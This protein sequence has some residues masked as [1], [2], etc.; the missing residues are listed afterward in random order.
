MPPFSG[1]PA[2]KCSGARQKCVIFFNKNMETTLE[3][4]KW[5]DVV[6][7][8]WLVMGL[9]GI[10]FGVLSLPS[11]RQLDR[12]KTLLSEHGLTAFPELAVLSDR[13]LRLMAP[14]TYAQLILSLIMTAA[15][16][17]FL[18]RKNSGRVGLIWING[19]VGVL[20]VGGAY[21][22][23]SWFQKIFTMQGFPELVKQG[24]MAN[25]PLYVGLLIWISTVLFIAPLV[26]MGWYFH[27]PVV[28]NYTNQ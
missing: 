7:W 19:G 12:L 28:R 13:L 26:W 10:M 2:Q 18:N 8:S 16:W 5:F 25:I 11:L 20:T 4:P 23:W 17:L 24:L 22:M 15:A 14:L 9:L 6:G 1:D 3:K 21:W 27:N